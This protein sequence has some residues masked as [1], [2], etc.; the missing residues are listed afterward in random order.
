MFISTGEEE[1]SLLLENGGNELFPLGLNPDRIDGCVPASALP[2]S[3][4][5]D[6]RAEHE[7]NQLEHTI[8][9]LEGEI[10]ELRLRQKSV[11][12]KRR[13]ALNKILEIKGCIRV[14][15]RVRPYLLTER[16]RIHQPISVESEKIVV[17]SGGS[18][19]DFGFDKVFP[20][21]ASQDDVFVEVAPILRSALD[22]HNVCILAYG[23]TGTGK[24]FTMDGT[25]DSPGIVPRVLKEIFRQS[26]VFDST[27]SFTFSLSML[28]VY[29]GNLRDLLAPKS[30]CRP[31][32]VSRCN[33]NIQTDPR[34]SVEIEGLTDVQISNFTKASW[35][36][37]KGRRVRSTSWTNVNESSSRSHCCIF[38]A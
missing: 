5:T 3:P 38:L 27:T 29:L 8:T 32:S 18:R 14:F 7:K 13:E 19:K 30:S 10:L 4:F 24:T 12:D 37:T 35:W 16:R 26:S 17:R 20:Q 28:E 33:L 6:Q 2:E 21:E 15:C 22:G 9:S 23:Q 11:D 34:G 36:Y 31:H 1:I 25:D